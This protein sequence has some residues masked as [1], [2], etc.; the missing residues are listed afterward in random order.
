MNTEDSTAD[1]TQGPKKCRSVCG[2]MGVGIIALT[3]VTIMGAGAELGGQIDVYMRYALPA[4]GLALLV[5][6]LVRRERLL[7]SLIGFVLL[8]FYIGLHFVV[9]P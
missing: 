9:N 7:W 4:L 1:E 6:A 5:C 3:F 8:A 2:L